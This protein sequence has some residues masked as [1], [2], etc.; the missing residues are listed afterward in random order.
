MHIAE[1]V[2]KIFFQFVHFCLTR[3]IGNGIINAEAFII[4]SPAE[5]L[6]D[7]PSI[8]YNNQAGH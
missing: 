1:N 5:I 8:T 2:Q 4:P 6:S 7:C 3:H